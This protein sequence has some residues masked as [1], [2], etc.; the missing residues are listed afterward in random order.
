MDRPLLLNGFMGAG[1]TTVG[2]EV[3]A[4][5]G[6]PFIDL[7]ARVEA[8]AG[9]PVALLFAEDGE[10]AF[11]SLEAALLSELLERG[12][13]AVVALGGGALLRRSQRLAAIDRAVVI[14]LEATPASVLKRTAGSDTRP[15]LRGPDPAA[16]VEELLEQRR[17]PYAECHARIGTDDR[18]PEA[19]ASEVMDVWRR[20]PIAVAAGDASY[21][22]D[23]GAGIV[24]S[25]LP[26]EAHGGSLAV[27]VTDEHVAPL[28]AAPVVAA[29]AAGGRRVETLVLPAGEEHKNAETLRSIWERCLTHGADRQ[30]W[31]IGLG[32]GVV[33]DVTGFAAATWM[34]GARW[35]GLP[36][37]LL[38]MVDASVGGKT[39]ID[40]PEAKNVVG[41]FWQPKSVLCDVHFLETEPERG[42]VSALAEVIKTALIGDPD[43]LELVE[44]EA[45]GVRARAPDLLVELVRRSVRVKARIVSADERESG[46]RACLNFG[47]TLGHAL[48][49]QGGYGHLRH[50]EAVSLGLI[51][52]LRIGERLGRTPR[53]LTERTLA[54]LGALG[55]PTRLDPAEVAAAVPLLGHDKKRS[56]ATLRFVVARDVGDVELVT[57]GVAEVAELAQAV[58]DRS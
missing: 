21:A 12:E 29:L 53:A 44:Q 16:R 56:G 33:T 9:K 57:L 22:V 26:E 6:R 30:S 45:R 24:S 4:R 20:S 27:L 42:F 3:A 17:E 2:R 51:A 48:E 10:G 28:H 58:V 37:T 11:R 5:A 39:A 1:K 49:A 38:A 36:T 50:G 15:L 18:A 8:R 13:P 32:G 23:V 55:L 47:H 52:A 41:A 14:T 31:F 46:L 54:V 7:D 25:R 35:V 19:I 34:R 40:L 43:L